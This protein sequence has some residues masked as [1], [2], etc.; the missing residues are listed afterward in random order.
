MKN[1]LCVMCLVPFIC[2][3]K[4]SQVKSFIE[5]ED[6][7][8]LRSF[9]IA[10]SKTEK[11]LDENL[12]KI[13]AL[14]QDHDICNQQLQQRTIPFRCFDIIENEKKLGLKIKEGESLDL[15][16][17]LCAESARN[18]QSIKDLRLQGH[19]KKNLS[20]KCRNSLRDRLQILSYRALER[21]PKELFQMRWQ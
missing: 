11:D 7:I 3:F 21:Q 6:W 16:D 13:D 5:R 10:K 17:K 2:A 12:S 19:K 9:V 14:Q 20:P 18:I 1:F 15:L 4:S 8:A